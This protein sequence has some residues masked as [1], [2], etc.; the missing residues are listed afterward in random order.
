MT[1]QQFQ[2]GPEA[3]QRYWARSFLGWPTMQA[4]QPNTTHR[5]LRELEAEGRLSGLIT[6][7]VDGLHAAAGH[8]DVVELHGRLARV[9]CL[10]C[11]ALTSRHDLQERLRE[12]NAGFTAEARVLPD[13]DVALEDTAGFVV[14]DCTSCGGVLKP[15]VVYFGENVPPDR[16]VRCRA[17]V[18]EA[19]ALVVLGSSLH[20]FS[21]R[22]FVKQAHARGIPI[23][24]V[25]RGATRADQL[26]SIKVDAGCAETLAGLAA[27]VLT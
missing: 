17:L 8:R 15:D 7:N 14:A 2:S 16:V 11:G 26:A 20:V 19:E 25:N 12:L 21:G 5:I 27:T 3:R 9:T 6:Q 13:G 22:R 24:I 1:L 4:V 18:E 10:D 23:A